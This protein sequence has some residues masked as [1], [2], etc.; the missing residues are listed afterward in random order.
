M[1]TD[2]SEIYIPGG[3]IEKAAQKQASEEYPAEC[4][5]AVVEGES[6][7]EYVRLT[8]T[9]SSPQVSF[10]IDER[11]DSPMLALIHSHTMDASVAPSKVD[12][13]S[14]QAMAIPWGIIGNRDNSP[15]PISWFGDQVPVEPLLGR[16]FLSGH[17][18]CWGLVRDVYRTQFGITL[19]NIP[20]DE[21]WYKHEP[22]HGE[23]ENLLGPESISETGFHLVPYT[24]MRAGDVLLGK[25]GRSGVV[26]HC[27]L[28][29]GDHLIL[30]HLEDRLSRRDPVSPWRRYIQFVARHNDF[31]I[32]VPPKIRTDV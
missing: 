21:N 29:T 12:M 24:E 6:G 3:A 31:K 20:R 5:G 27:G 9:S 25:I 17:R 19:R 18:D 32:S 26:N 13:A 4:V 7:L 30:H 15:K 11:P 16:Q 14:Q 28:L 2:I 8:N 10:T 22:P 23:A 1:D